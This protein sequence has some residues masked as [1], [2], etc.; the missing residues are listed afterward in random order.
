VFS[1]ILVVQL[2]STIATL[3]VI[4]NVVVQWVQQASLFGKWVGSAELFWVMAERKE[5]FGCCHNNPSGTCVF[6]TLHNDR[7][8]VKLVHN[9]FCFGMAA[10]ILFKGTELLMG[11]MVRLNVVVITWCSTV[12]VKQLCTEHQLDWDKNMG[13]SFLTYLYEVL[14]RCHWDEATEFQVVCMASTD[15]L[16][17]LIIAQG[18]EQYAACSGAW[19]QNVSCTWCINLAKERGGEPCPTR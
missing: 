11:L 15:V 3:C 10:A 17:H 14:C 18:S 6:H 1:V 12:T 16:Y 5:L 4:T 2:D 8:P 13:H 7:V 19:Q 9:L